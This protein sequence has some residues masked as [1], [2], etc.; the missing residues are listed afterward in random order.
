ME[1][2]NFLKNIAQVMFGNAALL[3]SQVLTGF[4]LPKL[5]SV[6]SFGNYRIFMLYGTYAGLLHFGFVDGILFKYGGKNIDDIKREEISKYFSVFIVIEAITSMV[7][8]AISVLFFS[9]SKYVFMFFAI[10]IYSFVLNVVTFFQYFSQAIM[11]FGLVSSASLIQAA[12]NMG[13]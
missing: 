9:G 8:I 4:V 3:L 1:E 13:V 5:M 2:N 12:T 6:E 7:I 11:R 10:G